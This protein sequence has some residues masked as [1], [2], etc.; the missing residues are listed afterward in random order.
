M[1]D[2][3]QT[4]TKMSWKLLGKQDEL[5]REGFLRASISKPFLPDLVPLLHTDIRLAVGFD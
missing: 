1:Q 4:T 3:G 5:D 2:L